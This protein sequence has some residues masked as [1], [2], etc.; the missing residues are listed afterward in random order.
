MIHY[1]FSNLYLMPWCWK[2]VIGIK[3]HATITTWSTQMYQLALEALNGQKRLRLSWVETSVTS[4]PQLIQRITS[5]ECTQ[6]AQFTCLKS[7]THVTDHPSA[8]LSQSLL[9]RIITTGLAHST[10]A[11]LKSVL[12]RLRRNWCPG[13]LFRQPLE[14]RQLTSISLTKKARDVVISTSRLS[15]GH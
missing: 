4:M 12:L 2:I 1:H 7:I 6:S 8:P 13:N 3:I 15:N 5:I 11:R 14:T 10:Q 9:Q